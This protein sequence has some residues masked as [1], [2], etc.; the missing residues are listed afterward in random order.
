MTSLAKWAALAVG[1]G[2]AFE[3]IALALNI[4]YAFLLSQI[5]ALPVR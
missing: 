4:R 1:F 2:V 5:S 3:I